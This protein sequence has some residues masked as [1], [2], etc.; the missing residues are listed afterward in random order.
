[1]ALTT[2]RH[3]GT[4]VEP[5]GDVEVNVRW[6]DGGGAPVVE[7]SSSSAS[8]NSLL[9]DASTIA[10]EIKSFHREDDGNNE[11]LMGNISYV[12]VSSGKCHAPVNCVL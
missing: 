9:T 1:M 8:R 5:S 4:V 11:G 2:S 12:G 10:S 3:S 7:I 6:E